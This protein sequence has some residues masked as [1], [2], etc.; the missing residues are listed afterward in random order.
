MKAEEE[1]NHHSGAVDSIGWRGRRFPLILPVEYCP[2]G[3]LKSCPGITENIG[4]DGMLLSLN[5][6]VEVGQNMALS[7][8]IDDGL[9]FRMVEVFVEVVGMAPGSGTRK[10]HRAEVKFVEM[11]EESMSHLKKILRS[12]DGT[13]IPLHLH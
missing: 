9:D 5:E 11:A 10:E 3:R 6:A 7:L 1:I 12:L 8:F 13:D 2:P 4:E